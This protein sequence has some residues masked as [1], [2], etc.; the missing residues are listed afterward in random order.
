MKLVA[1]CAKFRSSERFHRGAW[2]KIGRYERSA[3]NFETRFN[4]KQRFARR[5]DD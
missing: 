1:F 3:W 4:C 5:A 2:M